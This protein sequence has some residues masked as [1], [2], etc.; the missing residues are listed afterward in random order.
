[1]RVGFYVQGYEY[2]GIEFLSA[3]LK[4][5]GHETCAFYDPR[6]W[7]NDLVHNDTLGR[8]FNTEDLLIEQLLDAQLDMLCFSVVTDNYATALRVAQK[9]KLRSNIPIVFGGI[10]VTSVPERVVT[11]ECIDYIVVGEGEY[12][13]LELCNALA[14]GSQIPPI[15]N[16]WHQNPNG[17]IISNPTRPT[18]SDLDELPFPDKDIFYDAVP[19]YH[20]D[21]Y[22]TLASRGCV[23]A[24]TFCNNSMYKRMYNKAG[25]GRW[26]R[27]RSVDNLIE[28][29]SLALEK[30][31]YSHASFWDEIFIDNREW[32]EE[33]AEK[34][35]KAIG[36]PFWCYGY[37]KYID[38]DL[39]A[40]MEKAGCH[41]MN[42][43]VQ[44]IRP[45]SRK[46]IKRGDKTEKIAEAINLVRESKIHLTTG[47]ILQLPGQ[48]IEE[49]FE[50]A[51]FYADNPPDLPIVG[52]L[53]YYPRT[54]IVKT[55]FEMGCLTEEDIEEIEE[56]EKEQPFI[57]PQDEYGKDYKKAHVLIQ[58]TPWAPRWIV[59]FLLRSGTWKMLPTG[60]FVTLVQTWILKARAPLVGKVHYPES[61]TVVRMLKLMWMYGWAK[62]RWKWKSSSP[63]P[64]TIKPRPSQTAD[65]A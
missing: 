29:M 8:I 13:L 20:K 45:E 17:D 46:I 38:E 47:N 49:A 53:R 3:V 58:M 50:L 56:A 63:T 61:Y 55:G 52:Y 22:I 19:E 6:L 39:I 11:K 37:A 15:E 25:N 65:S 33:F 10:H 30:Y 5:H 51:D 57:L 16:V 59:K 28:E 44:T 27:R 18:I 21:H 35:P 2:V 64:P 31:N 36:K 4:Q 32:I 62:L 40:L 43:G 34:Y 7:R 9:V 41:E 12:A 24:C 42:V 23:Y 14:Q 60:T 54:E 1:M 48:P 26:H